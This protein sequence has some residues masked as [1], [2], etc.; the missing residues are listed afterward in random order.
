MGVTYGPTVYS[1]LCG[2]P[3]GNRAP[4]PETRE[5]AKRRHVLFPVSGIRRT[6]NLP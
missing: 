5:F 3:P 4:V 2:G 1:A 6:E